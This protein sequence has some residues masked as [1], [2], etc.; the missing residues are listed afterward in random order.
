MD[1]QNRVVKQ[2]PDA[3]YLLW[4]GLLER[5]LGRVLSERMELKDARSHLEAAISWVEPL[6]KKEPRLQGVRPLLALAYR[7]LA[8][9]HA[10]GGDAT[11]AAAALR[12]AEE[13][14]K[15]GPPR[16]RDRDSERP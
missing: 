6:G 11:A 15:N 16:P 9:V 4:L 8:Q 3:A 14:G 10:R 1:L 7:D 12:K 5:A 2:S 13:L